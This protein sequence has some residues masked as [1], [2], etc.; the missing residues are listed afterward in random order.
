MT[1]I[2]LGRPELEAGAERISRFNRLEA[3][4][5]TWMHH[6]NGLESKFQQDAREWSLRA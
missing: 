5:R 4:G 3:E 1:E 6:S 2:A